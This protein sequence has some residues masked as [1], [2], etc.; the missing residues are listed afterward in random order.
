[1]VN[2]R[3]RAYAPEDLITKR[4]W[5]AATQTRIRSARPRVLRP[6]DAAAPRGLRGVVAVASGL[7]RGTG[8]KCA[9]EEPEEEYAWMNAFANWFTKTIKVPIIHDPLTFLGLSRAWRRDY[10]NWIDSATIGCAWAAFA[11]AAMPG[12]HVSDDL[13]VATAM[14]MW[15]RFCWYLKNLRLGWA[16]FVLMIEQIAWDLRYYLVYFLVVLLMFASASTCT[17]PAQVR[18]VRISRRRR[19]QRVWDL[20]SIYNLILLG[21]R[22]VSFFRS[23]SRRCDSSTQDSWESSIR[24]TSTK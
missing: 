12:V 23:F 4:K 10:W 6:A 21:R 11:R 8:L 16:K 7:A 2:A 5:N 22:S 3:Y 9:V 13:A 20:S 1:M 24:T 18:R 19:A 15:I 14:L 17:L